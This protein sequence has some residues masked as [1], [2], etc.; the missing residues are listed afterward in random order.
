M[1]WAIHTYSSFDDPPVYDL[2]RLPDHSTLKVLENNE[3]LRN[4]QK[5]IVKDSTEFF[6]VDIGDGVEMDGYCIKPPDM[7]INKEYPL[8]FYIYGEPAGQTVL[9]RWR[10]STQ[11]MWHQML[12]CHIDN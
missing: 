7:D 2:I 10:R 1:K 3:T 5:D 6:R 11:Y 8:F 12:L 9:D 4:K